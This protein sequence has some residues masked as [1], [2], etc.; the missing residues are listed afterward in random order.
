MLRFT[1]TRV[2]ELRCVNAREVWAGFTANAELEAN[3]PTMRLD[4]KETMVYLVSFVG[5]CKKSGE[6][7]LLVRI[8]TTQKK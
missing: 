4:R 2:D 1:G 7:E 8:I 3:N 6:K 5:Y